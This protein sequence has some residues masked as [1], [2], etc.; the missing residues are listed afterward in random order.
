MLLKRN[1]QYLVCPDEICHHP[2]QYLPVSNLTIALSY[3]FVTMKNLAVS[4]VS[5]ALPESE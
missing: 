5:N 4:K 1:W 3:T 2:K